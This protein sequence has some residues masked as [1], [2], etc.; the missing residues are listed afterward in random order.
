MS[1]LLKRFMAFS[2]MA[3]PLPEPPRRPC[4]MPAAGLSPLRR[5]CSAPFTSVPAGRLPSRFPRTSVALI[6]PSAPLAPPSTC[7]RILSGFLCPAVPSARPLCESA[8][9]S[10]RSSWLLISSVVSGPAPP[11]SPPIPVSFFM[12]L[13][14]WAFTPCSFPCPLRL[15]MPC[16]L[17]QSGVITMGPQHSL[18]IM[19]FRS[20]CICSAWAFLCST[21]GAGVWIGLSFSKRSARLAG[22]SNDQLAPSRPA[23][24]TTSVLGSCMPFTRTRLRPVRFGSWTTP[25]RHQA[26]LLM[27]RRMAI[28]S[29][30]SLRGVWKISS[31]CG[32]ELIENLPGLPG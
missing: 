5:P 15:G 18:S 17:M 27:G 13:Y 26:P 3:R 29:C 19:S 16:F 22:T 14:T 31:P 4:S 12:T 21:L 1:L 2:A 10:S 28:S 9:V 8:S 32:F 11:A 25:S 20:G 6:P 7:S 24:P 30:S 23:K